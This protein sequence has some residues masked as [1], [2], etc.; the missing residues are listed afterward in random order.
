MFSL[1]MQNAVDC[2]LQND[3]HTNIFDSLPTLARKTQHKDELDAYLTTEIE[4]VGD[5]L[6]WW[7]D[8]WLTYTCLSRMAVDYLTIPGMSY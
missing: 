8:N 7:Q 4:D 3:M 2:P 6:K 5:V 1:A